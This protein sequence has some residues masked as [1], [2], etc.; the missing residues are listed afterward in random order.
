MFFW[1]TIQNT[2]TLEY[3]ISLIYLFQ[4]R[5]ITC[6]SCSHLIYTIWTN[7]REHMTRTCLYAEHPIP[8]ESP[9]AVIITS[10]L[11]RRLFTRLWSAAKGICVH[12]APWVW[13]CSS[14]SQRRSVGSGF[15]AGH[16]RSYTLTLANHE[17]FMELAMCTGALTAWNGSGPFSPSEEKLV[18][19]QH[20]TKS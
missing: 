18:M 12:S 9:F 17:V 20:T 13:L 15:H 1:N 5:F 8:D 7:V 3:R 6:T 19:L 2:I 16:L 4:W 10:A 11:L 14:L